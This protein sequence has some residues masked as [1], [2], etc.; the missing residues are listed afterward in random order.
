MS[1]I[2]TGFTALVTR[3]RATC[4]VAENRRCYTELGGPTFNRPQV[5]AITN[6]TRF[7]V[8]Q[9][10]VWIQLAIRP[11]G[12]TARPQGIAPDCPTRW[13]G[14]V[15]QMVHYPLGFGLDFVLPL[16]DTARTI[17]HRQSLSSGLVQC[18]DAGAPE[19][20]EL[21]TNTLAGWG[22]YDIDNEFWMTEAV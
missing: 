10:A 15:T 1:S 3:W 22:R 17:F 9:A 16:I 21:D 6:A 2:D 12:G 13:V 11:I 7:A 19:W 5:G 14:V 8:A 4:P 20:V 18:R